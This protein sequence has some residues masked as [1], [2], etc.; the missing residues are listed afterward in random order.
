MRRRAKTFCLALAA[1][2]A[3]A[4]CSA[5][6]GKK[7]RAADDPARQ[8]F[9]RNCAMCHGASGEGKQIGTLKVPSLHEGRAA[10]D[11]DER[12]SQQVHD[13]GNGM[14]PFKFTLTDDQIHDLIRFVREEMQGRAPSGQ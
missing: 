3:F 7:A 4:S 2:L 8:L 14:P 11:T 1:A 10:T 5:R 6:A 13:G 12:L 9:Q